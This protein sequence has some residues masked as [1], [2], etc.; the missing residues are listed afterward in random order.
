MKYA[1]NMQEKHAIRCRHCRPGTLGGAQA[2]P[3]AA[4]AALAAA[5]SVEEAV[6]TGTAPTAAI[7]LRTA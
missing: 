3:L 6:S 2:V 4:A 5:A 1:R 7:G